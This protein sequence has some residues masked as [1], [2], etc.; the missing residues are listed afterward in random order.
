MSYTSPSA[1]AKT[2]N[3]ITTAVVAIAS[4]AYLVM[5]LGNTH[6]PVTNG[7]AFLWVR[8]ADWAATTP[9]LLL[10]LGLL[11]GA[12]SVDIAWVVLCDLLMIAAGFAGA[13]S[14]GYNAA[15]P[16]FAFGMAAF[17]P[18]LHALAVTFPAAA[19][20]RG[21]NAASLFTK[22]AAIM[23]VTWS[24]YPFIWATGEGSQWSSVDQETIAYAAMDITAKC[25]FGFVLV[26][27]H[28]SV[29]DETQ[30]SS[31]ASAPKLTEA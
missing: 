26:S 20:L 2:T 31:T 30:A 10:D 4:L 24:A 12:S 18:V 3:L 16:L 23:A 5:A 19:R 21:P 14:S 7:R 29:E 22:L 9:L 27:G 17:V 8:Y 25:V 13:T 15:W 28:A 6:I 11:A 1:K